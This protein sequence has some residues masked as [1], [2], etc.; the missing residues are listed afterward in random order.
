VAVALASGPGTLL[1]SL[2]VTDS[3]G[4]ATFANLADDSAGSIALKLTASGLA[5]ISTSSVVVTPAAPA[6]LVIQ[7]QPSAN[8]TAGLSFAVPPII[9]EEDQ[10]GNVET[11]DSTTVITVT[12]ATGSGPLI[13]STS[14]VVSGGLA[15]F[16]G[17]GDSR[18]E[19]TT[20]K[21]ASGSLTSATSTIINV[22]KP[23]VILS[24]TPSKATG[25][26]HQA[27]TL[28]AT[29]APPAGLAPPTG[30]VSF[31]DGSTVLG[32]AAIVNGRATLTTTALKL[33]VQS[34]SVTYPGD[35]T[36]AAGT[37]P[38]VPF[39][40]GDLATLDFDGDGKSDIAIFD[41]TTATFAVQYSG[42]GSKT[43]QLGNPADVNIPVYGDFD[44]DGKTDFA[45]Y[46]QTASTFLVI[47]SGGGLINVQLGNPRDLNTPVAGS[48]TGNG[49]TNL[50]I[51]D[52]TTA[53]FYV[54]ESGKVV[55]QQLGIVKDVN[56]PV[57]GDF[58]G[59]G[60]TDFAVFDQT[61]AT[62]LILD[63][64]GGSRVQQLG[65]AGDKNIPIAADF[66]GDGKT[67]LAVFD[68]VASVFLSLESGGGL[69]NKQLG[70]AGDVNVPVAGDFDGEGRTDIAVY[71]QT[72]ATFLVLEWDG[73][74]F[75]DPYGNPK[76][77]N[78]PG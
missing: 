78:I 32:S 25:V 51:F 42:G 70:I 54:L 77:K 19:T 57:A 44:G 5:G 45:I 16:L 23:N 33:G 62:F 53:T 3:D 1:G 12:Q 22:T 43:Q 26:D 20:L 41:Q 67:D 76:H 13:G 36:Y 65:V 66:D 52:Q 74:N 46:D 60:K 29:V 58:D 39:H 71:D 37:S 73:G 49:K 68:P 63:S 50:A 6:K 28:T 69:I 24:W 30:S 8:V 27:I 34:I 56:I 18:V 64:G 75:V 72:Q 55:A 17:L 35:L 61:L 14:A 47:E 2:D 21:F 9:G 10:Y 4:V 40:V 11:T 59:D 48:F 31:L 15:K 7:A 38:A